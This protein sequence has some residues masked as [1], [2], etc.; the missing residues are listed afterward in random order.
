ME[1]AWCGLNSRQFSQE[2]TFEQMFSLSRNLENP[3]LPWKSPLSPFGP[4]FP[5]LKNG[6]DSGHITGLSEQTCSKRLTQRKCSANILSL[7]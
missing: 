4:Q 7:L 5:H 1:K 3:K 2:A 6:N